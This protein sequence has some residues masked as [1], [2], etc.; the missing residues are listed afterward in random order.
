MSAV[1]LP[2][3][4]ERIPAGL[5]APLAGVYAP[6]YWDILGAFYQLEFER[7]PQYLVRETAQEL[8]AHALRGSPFWIERREELAALDAELDAAPAPA[9]EAELL[10]ATARRLLARLE[11]AGWFHFEYR[12]AIG[13]VLSF[14][15][16]AARVLE[17]LVRV[18]RDEQPLF[19][20]FA[21]AI[22]ALLKPESIAAR[23]GVALREA[24]RHTLELMRELKILERNI[25]A[26]TQRLLDRAASAA[27]V[28]EEG[29]ERYRSAVMANYHRLKTV[30][31]L[32]KFRSEIVH[33]LDAIERDSLSLG[34]A[35]RWY[36]EQDGVDGLAAAAAVGDDL[37]LLRA[38]FEALPRLVD[39]IDERNARFSGVALRK[40]MYL[41]RHD[42]RM[43]G[44]LQL[45]VDRL[46]RDAAP[47]LD[48]DVHACELLGDAFLYT[49][50]KKRPRPERQPLARRP[51]SDAEAL[52]PEL[53]ARLRRPFARA[54]IDAYV[55]GLMRGRAHLAVADLP[56]EADPDYL[57]TIYMLAY[58]VDGGSP[59][60]FERISAAGGPV[61]RGAYGVPA[62]SVVRRR[63]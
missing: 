53:A 55:D 41:L 57:R 37:R 21:H 39:E 45:I 18:A 40:L 62:G 20:G 52:R 44:Q 51:V 59:Y 17:T 63:K 34:G 48:L 22:A 13:H 12:S 33:R 9:D 29:L 6:L 26:F 24:R 47:E 49:A 28:L 54:R 16:H 10:R 4:F 42:K 25:Y 7:E 56:L 58:G 2:Q 50:P 30:D 31:N 8:V 15:P 23:P 60:R 61:R 19:Q 27:A 14:H 3:L 46:A 36:A 11:R 32:Y 1:G 43:E 5:F 35:A 38:Q